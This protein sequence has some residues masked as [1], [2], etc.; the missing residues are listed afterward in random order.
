MQMKRDEIT[1]A[2]IRQ[3]NVEPTASMGRLAETIGI[4]RATLHRHFPSREAL[5]HALG[6]QALDSWEASQRQAGI[7]E[8]ARSG[9]AE[10]IRTALREMLSAYVTDADEHGFAL[11]DHF[12]A[13]LPDLDART[14]ELEEREFAF[15]AAA[16]RAG[17]LRTDLPVRWVGNTVYGL[18]IAVRDSLRRGDIARRDAEQLLWT[19]FVEGTGTS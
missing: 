1:A 19:S 6:K 16:Q 18:L 13:Q 10:Q 4:S 3:L 8:A 9:D 15:Y 2:A 11:T 5:L 14:V 12:I 17:V 7:D